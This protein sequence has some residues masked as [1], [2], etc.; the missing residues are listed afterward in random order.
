MLISPDP[1]ADYWKL[2]VSRKGFLSFGDYNYGGSLDIVADWI[3]RVEAAGL[4]WDDDH[5]VMCRGIRTV[6]LRVCEVEVPRQVA[7]VRTNSTRISLGVFFSDIDVPLT[8]S[9]DFVVELEFWQDL[10]KGCT[11]MIWATE[12]D[13]KRWRLHE[14]GVFRDLDA[15]VAAEINPRIG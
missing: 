14:D 4:D 7:F 13:E 8:N 11:M 1:H 6:L 12:V 9:Y 10:F 3:L 5:D 15:W 2:A